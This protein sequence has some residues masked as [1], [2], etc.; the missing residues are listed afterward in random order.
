MEKA[1]DR[2][3]LL[4][5]LFWPIFV[6]RYLLLENL[7]PAARYI[8]IHCALDDLIPFH[9][10]FLIPYVFWYV[11][12]AGMHLY[13]LCCDTDTFRKYSKFLIVSISLSTVIFLAFPSCQNL[14]PA[15]FPRDNF[16]TDMVAF[17]YSVDTNTNVLPSEHVI[18]AIAVMLASWH[19]KAINQY[20]R[21]AISVI[22]VLIS[23]STAFMKQHS[24]LDIFAAL[25][26]CLIAYFLSFPR[27]AARPQ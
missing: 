16:L 21:I 12:I 7:N 24:V 27:T 17:L 23:L 22:A 8:P 5:L 14:R 10:G 4:Y 9:E 3:N 26:I 13:T 15:A 11:F 20:H 6:A 1:T 2:K 18:G 19:C 25:P